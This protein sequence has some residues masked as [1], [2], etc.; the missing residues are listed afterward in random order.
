MKKRLDLAVKEDIGGDG[1]RRVVGQGGG[2]SRKGPKAAFDRGDAGGVEPLDAPDAT[3]GKGAVS[4]L[5]ERLLERRGA[6]AGRVDIESGPLRGEVDARLA[7]S[8][9]AAGGLFDR[10][11]TPRTVHPSDVDFNLHRGIL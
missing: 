3:V 7:N 4:A 10:P 2:D 1:A 9:H 6:E 8:H 5:E 11:D